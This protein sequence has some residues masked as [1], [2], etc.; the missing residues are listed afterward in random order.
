[1]ITLTNALTH[2]KEEEREIREEMHLNHSKLT[3][4]MHKITVIECENSHIKKLYFTLQTLILNW[5]SGESRSNPHRGGL[6]D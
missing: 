6:P 4:N 5:N 3:T 2:L 1:M